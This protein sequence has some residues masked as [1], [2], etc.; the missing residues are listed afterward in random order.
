MSYPIDGTIP[1]APNN[2]ADDQPLMKDNFA[3]IKSFLTVDHIAPG[4]AKNGYHNVV[5]FS[6]NQAPPAL[7]TAVGTAV[8]AFF[9]NLATGQS[10]PFWEN[11]LGSFQLLGPSNFTATNGSVTLSSGL[12]IKFGKVTNPNSTTGT[13]SYTTAFP[14]ATLGVYMTLARN[15]ASSDSIWIDKTGTTN[16]AGFAWRSSTSLSSAT[17]YFFWLAIGN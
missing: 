12:I 11:A 3:N 8:G 5:R 4:A 6:Q 10:W 15:A 16:S 9:A 14:S 13:V 2:P 17:D 1:N 7:A